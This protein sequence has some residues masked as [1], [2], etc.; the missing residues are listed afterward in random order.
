MVATLKAKSQVLSFGEPYACETDEYIERVAQAVR[1][2]KKQFAQGERYE[3]ADTL[4]EMLKERRP[5]VWA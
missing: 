3:G 2:S 4:F 1:T 5:E